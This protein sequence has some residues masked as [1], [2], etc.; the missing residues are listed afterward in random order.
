MQF[1]NGRGGLLVPQESPLWLPG[2]DYLEECERIGVLPIGGG[3][4]FVPDEGE[5]LIADLVFK[6]TL[7][8]RDADLE[9]GLFTTA[10]PGE[11]IT[12]AT[13]A[14]PTGGSYA[15]KTLTDA[16]WTGSADSRAY[17]QQTFNVSGSDYSANVY[18]YFVATKAAGGTQRLVLVE[19]D[20]NGP[21]DLN[22]GDSYAI[23]LNATVA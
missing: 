8:D 16:S 1:H 3:A 7:T 22:D 17:A 9:L 15:R 14:E 13:I 12:E 6:R 21:Y 4:G 10:A 11:T 2:R 5:A 23:T 19:I 20:P 18:G